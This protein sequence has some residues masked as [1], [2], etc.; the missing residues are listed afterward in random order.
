MAAPTNTFI[1]NSAVG[2]RKSLHNIISIL[3]RDETPFISMIGSGDADATYEE[4]QLDTLGNADTANS[5]LEGDE[6]RPRRWCR[7]CARAT[8]RRS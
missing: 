3:N 1:T 4:W 2:N 7:R 5:N 8:G 6:A